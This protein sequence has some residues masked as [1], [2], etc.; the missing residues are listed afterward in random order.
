MD[1]PLVFEQTEFSIHVPHVPG[2]LDPPSDQAERETWV[3]H[4]VESQGERETCF[5]G[6]QR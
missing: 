5:Y 3:Q 1:I 2:D 6:E 4:L